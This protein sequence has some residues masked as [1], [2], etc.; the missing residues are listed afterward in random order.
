MTVP[1]ELGQVQQ[2]ANEFLRRLRR[3][4][5]DLDR[6]LARC[7]TLQTNATADASGT[8]VESSEPEFPP[9]PPTELVSHRK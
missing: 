4:R 1:D 7:R 8:F 6:T 5:S 2:D 9:D 3:L